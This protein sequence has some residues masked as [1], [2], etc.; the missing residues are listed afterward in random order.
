LCT[1]RAC[2]TTQR[3]DSLS[4]DDGKEL[5]K[6]SPDTQRTRNRLP[7]PLFIKSTFFNK[8]IYLSY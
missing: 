8:K 4:L 5:T 1:C 2:I 3:K 7:P 6:A